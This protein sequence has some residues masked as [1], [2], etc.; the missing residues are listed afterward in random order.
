MAT[1]K[2][3]QNG[4]TPIL[5]KEILRKFYDF[6]KFNERDSRSISKKKPTETKGG[7]FHKSMSVAKSGAHQPNIKVTQSQQGMQNNININVN[8]L[9]INNPS[10]ENSKIIKNYLLIFSQFISK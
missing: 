3:T 1:I 5:K 9:I 7:Q 2:N 10:T 4:K 6:P 8:N